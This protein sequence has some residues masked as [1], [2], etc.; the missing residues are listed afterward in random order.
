MSS[1]QPLR[2]DRSGSLT[3]AERVPARFPQRAGRVSFPTPLPRS[4]RAD[5]LNSARDLDT[6]R[7]LQP[8]NAAARSFFRVEGGLMPLTMLRAKTYPACTHFPMASGSPSPSFSCTL[9]SRPQHSSAPAPTSFTLAD[10][11]SLQRQLPK[12]QYFPIVSRPPGAGCPPASCTRG[13]RYARSPASGAALH[14]RPRSAAYR[15][16]A[17]PCPEPRG[18]RSAPPS[19]DFC[20]G[21]RALADRSHG[22][23][24]CDALEPATP[25]RVRPYIFGRP[26]APRL[27]GRHTRGRPPHGL[28]SAGSSQTSA[29]KRPTLD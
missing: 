14:S 22:P 16:G 7:L 11:T 17:P 25:E 12:K 13:T 3:A 1:A 21:K 4:N 5:V 27:R 8:A 15:S 28:A 19:G 9:P 26:A 20:T 29:W 6:P 10:R 23:R 2:A 24:Q 18:P